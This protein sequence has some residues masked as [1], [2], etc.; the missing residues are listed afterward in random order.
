MHRFFLPPSSFEGALVTFPNEIGRQ[1]HLVLRLKPG[2]EVIALDGMGM[3]YRV[4][5]TDVSSDSTKG[6]VVAQLRSATEPRTKLILLLCLTQREKF[7]WI[8]QKCAE[9]GVATFIP[10]ISSRSLVQSAREVE[11]KY[12]RWQRILQEAAEQSHRGLVPEL[13]AVLHFEDALKLPE[14]ATC[15]C[16]I[17]WEE[18]KGVG[19]RAALAQKTSA[20]VAL[21]VGPEGGFSENEVN[22][23]KLAGF[24]PVTLGPRI[25]RMET[26]AMA[27]AALVL[28]ER[29]D[30]E[31]RSNQTAG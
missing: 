22:S 31:M 28:Y 9:I 30:M 10:V 18:E 19:L 12:E 15:C 20:D 25:L 26:A 7:E 4:R 23:A 14:L 11:G 17:P 16:L 13:R 24:I 2:T 6:E 1:I 3:E 21:L 27:A 8:L 29:G 5:L